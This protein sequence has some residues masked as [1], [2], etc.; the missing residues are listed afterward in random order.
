LS[1]L[2]RRTY[3]TLDQAIFTI[4]P[5]GRWTSTVRNWGGMI[6][7]K[8]MSIVIVDDSYF[9][10]QTAAR[11]LA[12]HFD[13]A[14]RNVGLTNGQFIL[15][16]L[17]DRSAPASM[18]KLSAQLSVDR[19]TL[20]AAL[21]PLERRR[22]LRIQPHS[23]D[24]RIKQILLTNRGEGLLEMAIPVWEEAKLKIGSPLPRKYLEKLHQALRHLRHSSE[25]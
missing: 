2:H 15:M 4:K 12:R 16:V 5:A 17:L 19:S 24:R 23:T 14:L 25:A 1:G 3:D 6:S 7:D 9:K 22:L 18:A 20:T 10:I 8:D 11:L 21:K 13:D